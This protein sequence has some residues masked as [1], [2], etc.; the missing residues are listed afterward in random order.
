[1]ERH[2]QPAGIGELVDA[3]LEVA[4]PI[5]HALDHLGR[6]PSPPDVDE[7]IEILKE[8]LRD[9]LTPLA[10]VLSPRDLRTT[11]AVVEAMVPLIAEDLCLVPHAQDARMSHHASG[12]PR[13]CSRARLRRR[14]H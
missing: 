4:A 14:G 9:V 10:T 12:R 8:L 1:M 2:T 5:A 11:T 6:A 7:G 3:I 13:P